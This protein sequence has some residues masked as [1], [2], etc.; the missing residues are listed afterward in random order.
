MSLG[1]VLWLSKAQNQK[2]RQICLLPSDVVHSRVDYGTN[3]PYK[4]YHPI[5]KMTQR[6]LSGF[7]LTPDGLLIFL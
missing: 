3:L 6:V 2:R 1:L 4:K 7:R 5:L